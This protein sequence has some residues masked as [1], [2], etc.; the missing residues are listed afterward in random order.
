MGTLN[1][2]LDI[3]R[4]IDPPERSDIGGD[5]DAA[6]D[7]LRAKEGE[8]QDLLNDMCRFGIPAYMHEGVVRYICGHTPPGDFL[9]AV[10]ENALRGACLRADPA[11]F[12]ALRNWASF[13]YSAVPA[14]CQGSRERVNAWCGR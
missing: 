11:N 5:E 2:G 1:D 7:D 14:R 12:A 3:D 6:Y 4:E 9:R 10:L 8:E 13:V